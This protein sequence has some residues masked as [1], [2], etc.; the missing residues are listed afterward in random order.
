M[1]KCTI[2]TDMDIYLAE[3]KQ[4]KPTTRVVFGAFCHNLLGLAIDAQANKSQRVA[5]VPKVQ[6]FS[7]IQIIAH[8]AWYAI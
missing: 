8:I 6:E 7:K 3:E 1:Q 4:Q 5:R 2:P